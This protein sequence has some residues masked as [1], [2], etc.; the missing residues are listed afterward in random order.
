MEDPY[1]NSVEKQEQESEVA[2]IKEFFDTPLKPL[3]PK[4]VATCIADEEDKQSGPAQTVH[5]LTLWKTMIIMYVQTVINNT[6]V[7]NIYESYPDSSGE[8][9]AV[10]QKVVEY[11]NAKSASR[12]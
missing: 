3:E 4:V 2:K 8:A 7:R 6:G 11:Y 1:V 5:L 10:S 9:K 12:K